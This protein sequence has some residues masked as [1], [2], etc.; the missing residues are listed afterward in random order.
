MPDL[1]IFNILIPLTDNQ[2]GMLHPPSKFSFGIGLRARFNNS[3]G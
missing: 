3:A 2:T 1:V